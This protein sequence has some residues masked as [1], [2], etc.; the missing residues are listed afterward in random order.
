MMIMIEEECFVALRTHS[1]STI[2]GNDSRSDCSRSYLKH[3]AH[4]ITRVMLSAKITKT[5]L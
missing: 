2:L 4:I 5:L 3:M 1:S